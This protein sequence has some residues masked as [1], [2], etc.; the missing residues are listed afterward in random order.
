MKKIFISCS[1]K[2]EEWK[3]RVNKHLQVFQLEGLW[4]TW[5]DRQ[6][7]VGSAWEKQISD[8]IQSAH[9]AVLLITTEFLISGFIRDK[10]V[11]LVL[12][13][14][15]KNEIIVFPVIVEP[16]SWQA[17]DWLKMHTGTGKNLNNK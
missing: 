16:W 6:I 12:E 8:E 5:D 15:Q 3:D 9:A 10:E 11:P 1:H 2:D 13:R 7:Q 14:W 17:I 4:R